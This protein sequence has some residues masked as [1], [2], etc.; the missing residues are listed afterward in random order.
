MSR[1]NTE[2]ERKLGIKTEEEK[3]LRI[4]KE[5][6][7]PRINTEEKKRAPE[8]TQKKKKSQN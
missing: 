3:S 2:V 6:K 4:N 5:E 8:L 1:I 7:S